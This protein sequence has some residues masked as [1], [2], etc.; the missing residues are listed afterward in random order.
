MPS[1]KGGCTGQLSVDGVLSKEGIGF[2]EDKKREAVNHGW[3]GTHEV[4][5]HRMVTNK[6]KR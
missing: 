3:Q 2:W 1:A 6:S 4:K 5:K